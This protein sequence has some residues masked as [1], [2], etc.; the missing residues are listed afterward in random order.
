[1][2]QVF[3]FSSLFRAVNRPYRLFTFTQWLRFWAKH[4]LK[5]TASTT[6]YNIVIGSNINKKQFRAGEYLNI[7]FICTKQAKIR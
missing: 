1:M 7:T 2:K 3:E 6:E 5:F 4:L